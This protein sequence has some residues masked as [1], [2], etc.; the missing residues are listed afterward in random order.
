MTCRHWTTACLTLVLLASCARSRDSGDDDEATVG[1][2]SVWARIT[3]EVGESTEY[4]IQANR[5]NY[6]AMFRS[7]V[8]ANSNKTAVLSGLSSDFEAGLI[9]GG[10]YNLRSC[11]ADKA[12]YE[13][14][15]AL[16]GAQPFAATTLWL[17]PGN[18]WMSTTTVVPG[19]YHLTVPSEE[20]PA[21]DS[22]GL[23]GGLYSEYGPNAYR[24]LAET[25]CTEDSPSIGYGYPSEY[26]Y[27]YITSGMLTVSD[28]G[29][30]A[31]RLALAGG[32]YQ[33]YWY[34]GGAGTAGDDDDSGSA[35]DPEVHTISIDATFDRCDIEVD[36]PSPIP[37]EPEP[38]S[39]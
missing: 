19:T 27:G 13:E 8:E 5:P 28:A 38:D 31:W 36:G 7:T 23:F 37:E 3:Y 30:S 9:D 39:R 18:P 11:L 16:Y 17:G 20:E 12:R 2:D 15:D 1:T 22:D 32:E 25:T 10:E 14:L 26:G 33:M 4:L 6:C 21:E 24:E 35:V 29:A 34:S